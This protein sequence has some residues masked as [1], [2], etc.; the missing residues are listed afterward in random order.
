MHFVVNDKDYFDLEIEEPTTIQTADKFF[1]YENAVEVSFDFNL[2][3]YGWGC[4]GGWYVSRKDIINMAGGLEALCDTKQEYFE[5]SCKQIMK[6]CTY[7]EYYHLTIKR[8]AADKFHGKLKIVDDL[9]IVELEADFSLRALK[10]DAELWR[11]Y[12]KKYPVI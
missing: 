1:D 3:G 10:T 12:A 4:G 9:E 5:Y 8:T 11:S 7:P 6:G 2:K